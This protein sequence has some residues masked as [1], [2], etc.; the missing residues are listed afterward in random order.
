MVMYSLL[1]NGKQ[2]GH[3]TWRQCSM[4]LNNVKSLNLL[5]PK[6]R[7][8]INSASC[9]FCGY[10][11]NTITP[12][13]TYSKLIWPPGPKNTLHSLIVQFWFCASWRMALIIQ[14]YVNVN[15]LKLLSYVSS[16]SSTTDKLFRM[17]LI[18][19]EMEMKVNATHFGQ[20]I[21]PLA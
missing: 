1:P 10:H 15:P 19:G 2:M 4:R 8:R 7:T 17:W 12:C 11:G 16:V 14:T 20:R 3:L 18:S 9:H 5:L 6:A 21:S 13:S